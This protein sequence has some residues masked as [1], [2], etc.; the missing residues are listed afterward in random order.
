MTPLLSRLRLNTVLDARH[1]SLMIGCA[2]RCMGCSRTFVGLGEEDVEDC[3]LAFAAL[4][5]IGVAVAATCV[6]TIWSGRGDPLNGHLRGA[7]VYGFDMGEGSS[8]RGDGCGVGV[9]RLGLCV[10]GLFFFSLV[11][12]LQ[13]AL[14]TAHTGCACGFDFVSTHA[15]WLVLAR[16]RMTWSTSKTKK[17]SVGRTSSL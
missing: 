3:A 17:A 8:R 15:A 12:S 11:H 4:R 16:C 1:A 2:F 5:L 7:G 6:C 14:A 13:S 9:R 10:A